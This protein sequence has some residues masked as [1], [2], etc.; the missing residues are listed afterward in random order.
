MSLIQVS[1]LTFCY[2]GSYDPVFEEVSFE[3]DT[4]WKLGFIGRN[5]Q[6]KTTFLQLLMGR[7]EYQGCLL[8]TSR[9][10]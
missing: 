4:D 3:L 1:H 2:E 6:G 9:C 10:V 7:Y 5:G 8:Y